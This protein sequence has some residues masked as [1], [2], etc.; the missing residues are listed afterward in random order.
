MSLSLLVATLSA[1]VWTDTNLK[2]FKRWNTSSNPPWKFSTAS[3][4]YQPAFLLSHS[5]DQLYSTNYS[6]DKVSIMWEILEVISKVQPG[7]ML[8]TSLKSKV[9]P[10]QNLLI[11]PSVQKYRVGF[12]LDV[13]LFWTAL[14]QC[15]FFGFCVSTIWSFW[16]LGSKSLNPTFQIS[17]LF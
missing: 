7:K 13:S 17:L 4:F 10:G 2:R 5:F 8:W 15:C 6:R 14:V 9:I 3:Y 16:N 1:L 12:A 11:R